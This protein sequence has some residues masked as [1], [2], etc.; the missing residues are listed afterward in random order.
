MKLKI[1]YCLSF[2]FSLNTNKSFAQNY[3]PISRLSIEQGLSNNSVRCI[4]QDHNNFMWFGTYD[5]LSRY[6][7]YEFKIFRNKLNDSN[8]LPHNY[9][10]AINEDAHNNLWVGTG[11]GIGIYNS[12]TSKWRRA[13]CI[14]FLNQAKEKITVNITTIKNGDEN[15]FIGTNGRGLMVNER[16]DTLCRQI[17]LEQ[18]NKMITDYNVRALEVD[19]K[20]NAW[21]FVQGVGL[22]VY[23]RALRKVRLVSS[24][25]KLARCI[26]PDGNNIWIGTGNGLYQ[27]NIDSDIIVRNYHEAP[28]QLTSENVASLLK[29]NHDNNLWIGTE[30]GGINVLDMHTGNFDYLL[31]GH[32]KQ[33]LSSESVFAIYADNESRKWI[34]TL[35]GGINIIDPWKGRFTTI[36]NDPFDNN[37]LVNNFV[38]S[39]YEDSLKQLWIGTDG[40]GF[41]IWNRDN[42]TFQNFRSVVGKNNSLSNNQVTS[43]KEDYE[44]NIWIATFGGGINKFNKSSG[45]F[46]HFNCMND[47]T[48]NEDKNV[49]LLYEDKAKNLWASTF[50]KGLLYKFNRRLNKF[51]VF[52]HTLFDLLSIYQDANTEIWAGDAYQ[53]I[54]ID[55]LTKKHQFYEIGKP[56]RAIYEDN[57]GRLWIGTEG[58]GLIL[59]DRKSGK[60]SN[61]YSD[62]NGLCN[63]SVLNILEDE[64][65]NLWL[66]TF[67]GLSKF[68]PADKSFRNFYQGDGLQSNQFLYSAAL[69]LQSDKLVFGGINGFSI[70]SP[71]SLQSRKNMPAV[72]LTDLQINNS[73]VSDINSKEIKIENDKLKELVLPYD[74]A[75]IFF[76]FAALEY[77]APDK[78]S[79]AYFLD[80]WDKNWNMAGNKRSANYSHLREGTYTLR[81]KSTNADGVWNPH[82]TTLKITVLPPWYR[83]WWAYLL[84]AI[85]IVSAA[86]I[87]ILYKARQTKLKYM[88]KL[89]Q[90]NAEK[91]REI[92][93]KKLSFFTEVSHE[94]R[95]PL[96]LI[97]NPIKDILHKTEGEEKKE[98][99]I[100][101]RNARRLLSLVDQLLLF[102]E[103]DTEGDKLKISLVNF[104]TLCYDVYL[105][106][107]Q[108]ARA[109]SID[110]RFE[111][112]SQKIYLYIDK[113][114]IEIA[115]FNILSNALKYVPNDGKVIMFIEEKKE[116]VE[117]RVLDNGLGIPSGLENKIF[118]KFYRVPSN[119]FPSKTGFG[120]GLY[121]VKHFIE[122]HDGEVYYESE[123]GK[124]TTFFVKLKKIGK[125]HFAG[126]NISEQEAGVSGILHELVEEPAQP[127]EKNQLE[128]IVTDK[129]SMLLVDDDEQLRKYV[130][131]IFKEKFLIYEAAGGD[132]ALQIAIQNKPD[133]II[134]DI[135]M[136]G[137]S[138]I[139]LCKSIKE[140]P[141]LKH[142]PF[143]LLTGISSA[144]TQLK[145]AELGADD[146]ITKPFEKDLLIAKVDNILKSRDVLKDYFY[147]EITL[148]ENTLKIS[149]EYKEFL[150]NCIRVVEKH[151]E[152]DEPFTIQAFASEM[153]MS[154]SALYKKIKTISGQSVNS[155]IRFIRLRKAAGLFI[156]TNCNVNEA[157]FQVG[158][159]DVKYFRTQFFKLFGMNPSDYIKKFRT[160]FN[161]KF[162][163]SDKARLN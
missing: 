92:N 106:F 53:L 160:P 118:D 35:K 72:L 121:L 19:D 119:T 58:G 39:F 24:I 140:S 69:K 150:E 7:G 28:K 83:T 40:G 37:S 71:G 100:I 74:E 23:D 18:D 120:I 149:G 48:G 26:L 147:N 141:A 87:F 135:S 66:S 86:Y 109:K 98:L 42:N 50:G 159:N 108:Q 61:R 45:T 32:H 124:G 95:T 154:H 64:K 44:G 161:K 2:L 8:S 136:N 153:S 114:K 137:M 151:L 73:P 128:E 80:G 112:E 127:E 103:A 145:G 4:F 93:E 85:A 20:K 132:E 84:Y 148:Q 54:H 67:N 27:Y 131:E 78:I 158:I 22:C 76:D 113:E 117:T 101:Y 94:F 89:T 25:I 30:G 77:T 163:L 65:G 9:I 21:L 14:N 91:E 63:N 110:Y 97:I 156:N 116:Y 29:D 52:D 130:F 43:I 56:V 6:D 60:I 12:L 38:S 96:S 15:M 62:E 3:P 17:P 157:A 105:S 126:E 82:E 122:S 70:F 99:N 41:S 162:T 11:Q 59:F 13:Y 102:R 88:V 5:G 107:V 144:E 49:W 152:D 111:C 16:N 146:Y 138:G 155:F 57:K 125:D 134:S 79:Y 129:Q 55:R 46:E 123:Q 75:E 133:I 81:L 90:L 68:N 34:G 36:Q 1:F 33:S 47:L 104:K 31:P 139:D 142:I 143:I 10:Y 115:L 51:E